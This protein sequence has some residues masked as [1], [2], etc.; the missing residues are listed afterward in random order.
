MAIDHNAVGAG[1]VDDGYLPL[2]PTMPLAINAGRQ[3]EIMR[4]LSFRLSRGNPK[5]RQGNKTATTA[6]KCQ[7]TLA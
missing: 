7:S 5:N 3:S 2:H 4:N 6:S 1:R